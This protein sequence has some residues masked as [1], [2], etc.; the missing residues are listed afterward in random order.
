MFVKKALQEPVNNPSFL[1]TNNIFVRMGKNVL[2]ICA[3]VTLTLSSCGGRMMERLSDVESYIDDRPDSALSVLRAID[4]LDLKTRAEKAKFSLLHAMALDKN[5][6]D[7]ADTRVV[8]PA[9]DYYSRHGS[10]EERLK[11]F[12]YMGTIYHNLKDYRQAIVSFYKAE[13]SILEDTDKNLVGVL[14]SKIAETYTSTEEYALAEEYIDKS[15]QSFSEC[16]RKDQE[17][18]EKIIKARMLVR[19]TKLEEAGNYFQQLMSENSLSH[20]EFGTREADYAMYILYNQKIDDALAVDH[21]KNALTINGGLDGYDQYFAYAY[22]LG[23]IGLTEESNLLFETIPHNTET[24]KSSYD[25]WKYRLCKAQG[26]FRDAYYLLWSAKEYTDSISRESINRSAS[27]AQKAFLE[28][29]LKEQELRSQRRGWRFL[30]L[31][32]FFLSLSLISSSYLLWKRKTQQE[33]NGRKDIIIDS[34]KERVRELKIVNDHFDTIRINR[35]RR[36]FK[37]LSQL[38]EGVHGIGRNGKDLSAEKLYQ[39]ISSQTKILGK[40]KK[41]QTEFEKLLNIE[42]D[43]IMDAFRNDF[44]NLKNEDY[45]L[46]SLVFAGFDNTLITLIMDISTLENTRVKKSRLKKKIKESDAPGKESYLYFFE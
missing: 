8:Q 28:N 41:S 12:M 40:D 19:Q 34:L 21:F 39:I 36:H 24:E 26:N 44:R 9:V 1:I 37:Y 31:F 25:Y 16:G 35:T 43:G 17:A 18:L 29:R 38:F 13:E 33:E 42:S 30:F 23:Y 11:A 45:R 27:I 4:T 15:I 14:Y 6:I 46:A 10:P 5:Y 7:T 3:L 20:R 2:I 32:L 22:S